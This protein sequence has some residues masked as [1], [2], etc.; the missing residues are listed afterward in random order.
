MI[1]EAALLIA[2]ELNLPNFRASNGWFRNLKAKQLL[3][4]HEIQVDIKSSDFEASQEFQNSFYEIIKNYE[5]NDVYNID[6]TGL[7]WK[8]LPDKTIVGKILKLKGVKKAKDRLTI[9]FGS[10]MLAKKLEPLIIGKCKN[11]RGLENEKVLS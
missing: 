10:N 6:E 11:P 4:S 9:L 7:F 3:K 8:L 5:L 1:K 2:K